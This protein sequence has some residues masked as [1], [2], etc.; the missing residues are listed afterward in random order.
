MYKSGK[1]IIRI[2]SFATKLT[3]IPSKQ[4]PRKLT[5]KGSDG[6]DYSYLLKGAYFSLTRYSTPKTDMS[7]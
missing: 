3:V 4:R 2:Q 6:C 7:L 5:L 1:P